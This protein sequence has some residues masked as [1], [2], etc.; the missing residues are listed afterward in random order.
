MNKSFEDFLVVLY[1]HISQSSFM[2]AMSD[3]RGSKVDIQLLDYD[4]E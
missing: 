3:S 1:L 4:S 2:F